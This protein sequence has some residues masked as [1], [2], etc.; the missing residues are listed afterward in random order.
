MKR[1]QDSP[2]GGTAIGSK[3]AYSGKALPENG[4]W[5]PRRMYSNNLLR[6]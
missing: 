3:I 2:F 6:G 5:Q 1:R 4:A